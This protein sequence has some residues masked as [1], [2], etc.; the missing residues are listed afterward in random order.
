MV[1]H[2]PN[3]GALPLAGAGAGGD[4]I[5]VGLRQRVNVAHAPRGGSGHRLL[6]QPHAL[7]HATGADLGLSQQAEREDL[8]VTGPIL[9]SDLQRPSRVRRALVDALSLARALDRHPAPALALPVL[10]GALGPGQ[11]TPR[12]RRT[13]DEQVLVGDPG[14]GAGGVVA[15]AF[16]EEAVEGPLAGRDALLDLTEEPERQAEPI[17]RIG[18]ILLTQRSFEGVPRRF[19]LSAFQKLDRLHGGDHPTMGSNR[20][21]RKDH[22]Q[23]V[24]SYGAAGESHRDAA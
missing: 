6:E 3:S 10:Q 18:G 11:P 8:E 12:G 5:A 7:G 19:P 23:Q 24:N 9:A 17:L 15:T 4:Q 13:V 16:A 1:R 14:G 21:W 20:L 22:L 2:A